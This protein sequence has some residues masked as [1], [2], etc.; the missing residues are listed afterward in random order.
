MKKNILWIAVAM[1]TAF[2]SG[3]CSNEDFTEA[4]ASIEELPV[5]NNVVNF[6]ATLEPKSNDATMRTLTDNDD[7]KL[8]ATWE[9]NEEIQIEYENTSSSSSTAKATV[10]S[11]DGDGKATITASLPNALDGGQVYL[12]YPY[13]YGAGTTPDINTAQIGTLADIS[14]HYD[15]AVDPYTYDPAGNSPYTLIV[16][17]DN[18]GTVPNGIVMKNL[19]TIWRFKIRN[20]D[21]DDIT[22]DVTKLTLDIDNGAYAYEV[23][24]S[25]LSDIYVAISGDNYT[26][27]TVTLTAETA[28]ATYVKTVTGVDLETGK[29]YHSAPKMSPLTTQNVTSEHIGWLIT[30]DGYVY[31]NQAAV[32]TASKTAVAMIAYI[33][34]ETDNTTYTNGLGL[35]LSNDIE[36]NYWATVK[37]TCESKSAVPNGEWMLPSEDN[38]KKMMNANGGDANN[39]TGLNAKISAVGGTT[40]CTE[41]TEHRYWCESAGASSAKRIYFKDNGSM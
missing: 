32:T 12:S 2:V 4:P 6:K 35:S 11:V 38:W 28:T 25:A 40:L 16:D 18:N 41:S 31:K 5:I 24:P 33:G 17:G 7:G 39:Y 29:F 22:N 26:G 15:F 13:E 27:S 9:V 10:T 34:S 23:T 3:A 14:A 36:Q 30:S 21:G 20:A 1:L 8:A 19:N 37:S